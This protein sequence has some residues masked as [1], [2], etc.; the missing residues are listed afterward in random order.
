MTNLGGDL[1]GGDAKTRPPE[2]LTNADFKILY[3]KNY[4]FLTTSAYFLNENL[5]LILNAYFIDVEK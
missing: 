1:K 2:T 5:E 3:S 4:L